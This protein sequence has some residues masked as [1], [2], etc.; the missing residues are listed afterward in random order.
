MKQIQQI[1]SREGLRRSSLF[2][3]LF[4]RS[5]PVFFLSVVFLS[6]SSYSTRFHSHPTQRSF[7]RISYVWIITIRDQLR[8]VITGFSVIVCLY[9]SIVRFRVD[10]QLLID[11]PARSTTIAVSRDVRVD[12]W[13]LNLS[14][15]LRAACPCFFSLTRM[16][17]TR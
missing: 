6:S 17:S 8:L 5:F 14:H 11:P 15:K 1:P 4:S 9:S 7:P 13:V 2:S 16:P 12:C 10:L 3:L